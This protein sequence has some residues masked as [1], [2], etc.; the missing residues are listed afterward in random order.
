[1]NWENIWS[2]ILNWLL[3]NG[4]KILVILIVAYIAHLVFKKVTTKVIEKIVVSDGSADP[5]AEEKR[6]KTLIKI[7]HGTIHVVLVIVVIMMILSEIGVDIGPLIAGAGIIGLAIGFGGQYLVKDVI[8]GLF[9]ILEN[10]YRVGDGVDIAGLAGTVEDITLR[11]TVLRDANGIVHHVPNG[12]ISTVSNKTLGT[13]KINIDVG[14]GYDTDIAKLE[15]VINQVGKE[16]FEDEELKK[17]LLEAPKFLRVN[18]LGD[19]AVIVKI[20]AEVKPGSQWSLSGELNKR[21]LERFREEGIEIPFP[22]IAVHQ[23]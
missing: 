20:V 3:T 9:I 12:Q 13:S 17:D 1:M 7:F 18:Q 21:I 19:S 16:M 23:K 11:K 4:V 6:E 22:Q 8:N 2:V 10:Q 5:K 14:V 15:E